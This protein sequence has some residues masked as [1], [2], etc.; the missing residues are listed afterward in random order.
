METVNTVVDARLCTGCGTCGCAC[1]AGAIEMRETPAGLPRP[2]VDPRRCTDCGLCLKVCSGV[3]YH[4]DLP[5][6]LD[7]IFCP[8]P[9]RV[10][11]AWATDPQIHA[12][13]QSGGVATALLTYL[14]Q[15]QRISHALVTQM[16]ADGSC[17]PNPFF[18]DSPAQLLE[19]VGSKYCQNPLNSALSNWPE[20]ARGVAVVGLPCHVHGLCSLRHVLAKRW[21]EAFELV[22]GLFCLQAGSY[23]GIEY[24]LRARTKDKPVARVFFRRKTAAGQRGAPCIEYADG[25]REDFPEDFRWE[26][27]NGR[28]APLRCR[29]CFDQVNRMSDLALGDPNGFPEEVVA[30]GRNL[31][32]VYTERGEQALEQARR[33]GAIELEEADCEQMWKGQLLLSHRKVRVLNAYTR[34]KQLG[35]AV[36]D[37]PALREAPPVPPGLATRLTMDYLWRQE[38]VATR[39]RAYRRAVRWNYWLKRYAGLRGWLSGWIQRRR[40]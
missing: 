8:P 33:D 32:A 24:L 6:D 15:R 26:F 38:A 36:P 39:E 17:R 35:R 11:L 20:D 31:V 30:K 16:A 19:S 14:M 23:L 2:K 9:R 10:V 1:P 7:S 21:G 29:F 22:I 28:F 4:F 18:A 25:E 12:I 3:Q 13:G 34:W 27:F 37:V 5:G 40:H